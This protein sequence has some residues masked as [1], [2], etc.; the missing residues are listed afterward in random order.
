M[1]IPKA[2]MSKKT[3]SRRT[4]IVPLAGALSVMPAI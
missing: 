3:I 2:S 1:M 4:L